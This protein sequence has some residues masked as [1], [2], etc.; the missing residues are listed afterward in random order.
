LDEVRLSEDLN[1]DIVPSDVVVFAID[2]EAHLASLGLVAGDLE[3]EGP[4]A[5]GRI[6]TG[7]LVAADELI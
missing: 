7:A 1:H 4:F 5:R 3:P 2:L 6:D